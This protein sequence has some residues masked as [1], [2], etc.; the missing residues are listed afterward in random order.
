MEGVANCTLFAAIFEQYL[1][2]HEYVFSH[3][4]QNLPLIHTLLMLLILFI[5]Y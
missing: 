2:R 1:T 3:N 5:V 4:P